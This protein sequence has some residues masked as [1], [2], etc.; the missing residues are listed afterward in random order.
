MADVRAYN[1]CQ[2]RFAV[3]IRPYIINNVTDMVTSFCSL[4]KQRGDSR[5]LGECLSRWGRRLYGV[6]HPLIPQGS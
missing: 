1:H 4:T 3:L 2:I 6:K 5:A